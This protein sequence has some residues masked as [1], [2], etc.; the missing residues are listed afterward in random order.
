M[1]NIYAVNIDKNG[2]INKSKDIK[3]GN[4]LFPFKY[5]KKNV[6]DCL[7]GDRG[8]WCATELKDS[9]SYSK[10]A[11]CPETEKQIESSQ[12]LQ[13]KTHKSSNSS[14]KITK[15]KS[16]SISSV[17]SS[18]GD[19]ERSI[20]DYWKKHVHHE[21]FSWKQDYIYNL[22]P[23]S[24][25][26]KFDKLSKEKQL[27][28]L[29]KTAAKNSKYRPSRPP[30]P[31]NPPP[32]YQYKKHDESLSSNSILDSDSKIIIKKKKSTK[33][34][35]SIKEISL[36]EIPNSIPN[37]VWITGAPN[38]LL[39]LGKHLG[40][41]CSGYV[42]N[43]KEAREIAE[44]FNP[45]RF[46]KYHQDFRIVKF[47]DKDIELLPIERKD[48]MQKI[49]NI[50][51]VHVSQ[52]YSM[53]N[54]GD[55]TF[56][57]PFIVTSDD[58]KMSV[59]ADI[60][61]DKKDVNFKDAEI[62]ISDN[63]ISEMILPWSKLDKRDYVFLRFNDDKDKYYKFP[64]N[65]VIT[66]KDISGWCYNDYEN[67]IQIGDKIKVEKGN[68][69][70]KVGTVVALKSENCEVILDK[71][72]KDYIIS[73]ISNL[74]ISDLSII[75]KKP[76]LI[77]LNKGLII[78]PQ[79][80]M[81]TCYII[82]I[83]KNYVPEG[84]D[85]WKN[86][87]KWCL[88]NI[89]S[90]EMEN[91]WIEYDYI[92]QPQIFD[93]ENYRG[94]LPFSLLEDN[95]RI[96]IYEDNFIDKLL[97]PTKLL[98][99]EDDFLTVTFHIEK[100]MRSPS[101]YFFNLYLSQIETGT[102]EYSIKN[103]FK[104][105][106]VW[107]D[108]DVWNSFS[109]PLVDFVL[110]VGKYGYIEFLP[111][112][113]S[114]RMPSSIKE[115]NAIR[116]TLPMKYERW[117]KLFQ[118]NENKI[119]ISDVDYRSIFLRFKEK[120]KIHLKRN[121][122]E[123]NIIEK[124]IFN[125]DIKIDTAKYNNLSLD[126]FTCINNTPVLENLGYK[127]SLIRGDI[128]GVVDNS[129]DNTFMYIGQVE[130]NLINQDKYFVNINNVIDFDD[131][132]NIK[133]NSE[134]IYKLTT[135]MG[136]KIKTAHINS[137][138][139]LFDKDIII[140]NILKETR[141][142]PEWGLGIN[143][144]SEVFVGDIVYVV[145]DYQD[146]KFM[147][148]YID[149]T[150]IGVFDIKNP[151]FIYH[152]KHNQYFLQR[153]PKRFFSGNVVSTPSL[154]P[155]KSDSSSDKKYV[156]SRSSSPIYN[157]TSPTY[158]PNSPPGTPPQLPYSP[159][160][161]PES[162]PYDPNSPQYKPISPYSMKDGKTYIPISVY[163]DNNIYEGDPILI[164]WEFKSGDFY[165]VEDDR[166]ISVIRNSHNRPTETW[167]IYDNE[168]YPETK[169][170]DRPPKGWVQEDLFY[171]NG[172]PIANLTM[173][174]ELMK[175][176]VANNWEISLQNVKSNGI[177]ILP[178]PPKRP[179]TKP[180]V[181]VPSPEPYKNYYVPLEIGQLIIVDPSEYKNIPQTPPFNTTLVEYKNNPSLRPD[182]PPLSDEEQREYNKFSI[183]SQTTGIVVKDDTS[184]T[185]KVYID[186]QMVP[187]DIDI[188]KYLLYNSEFKD[189][190]LPIE[191]KFVKE[192]QEI[193]ITEYWKNKIG[194]MNNRNIK[195][196]NSENR[197]FNTIY[198]INNEFPPD[199]KIIVDKYGDAIFQ[200]DRFNPIYKAS[201]RDAF[202]EKYK[203]INGKTFWKISSESLSYGKKKIKTF[204]FA[205]SYDPSSITPP[206]RG[207]YGG[208][209]EKKGKDIIFDPENKYFDMNDFQPSSLKMMNT[210]LMPLN[211]KN[212]DTEGCRNCGEK[213]CIQDCPK[214]PGKHMG[215]CNL[216]GEFGHWRKDCPK[217][218]TK[219]T[220]KKRDSD[221]GS[222]HSRNKYTKK[223]RSFDSISSNETESSS[224][225]K[226]SSEKKIKNTK[227]NKDKKKG[228]KKIS[229]SMLSLFTKK[230]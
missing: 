113:E 5:K 138:Y 82:Q 86:S 130:N 16:S 170:P 188:E 164:G 218:L 214:P 208:K 133:G 162:P 127:L 165:N 39:Y 197:F 177:H 128:V 66:D 48:K 67:D 147:V 63:F 151:S 14:S 186:V 180:L 93:I 172:D 184:N 18:N 183:L 120:D 215:A 163:H 129:S 150:T 190:V 124:I 225:K 227:K 46:D 8:K 6:N 168:D 59:K 37:P 1:E 199:E 121:T 209:D 40:N 156:K 54:N 38:T 110:G 30:S 205:Y 108:F 109:S 56:D 106:E 4:C 95:S 102:T 92:I 65:Q 137:V 171:D 53:D 179:K 75:L 134:I 107:L 60:M 91:L 76:D 210:N 217:G 57:I 196:Q 88:V 136:K 228:T 175:N 94:T 73:D 7:T 221:S 135:Q 29:E 45:E 203:T 192:I 169:N 158:T 89:P 191:R 142:L 146:R 79:Y 62:F 132:K 84:L 202:I 49:G 139:H 143:Y 55:G 10:Y 31:D 229:A 101:N 9:G 213:H 115:I 155:E 140:Y 117:I 34:T 24:K 13:K 224:S 207:W 152:L 11:Y 154:S 193:P 81:E 131:I 33:P 118:E 220:I 19:N 119:D 189:G 114:K 69:K 230:K 99:D 198:R 32:M 50:D 144:P 167:W 104:Y 222:Q 194:I 74:N 149:E 145:D 22:L 28:F 182:T 204:Y 112:K 64:C 12:K 3:E 100:E 160:Y 126:S 58:H 226:S 61:G 27:I 17:S 105:S 157:P 173:V 51:W 176:E 181:K 211:Y 21:G 85:P 116:K 174:A 125:K 216:C 23:E 47:N 148:K 159:P 122:K 123:D 90:V 78:S 44:N 70:G 97:V 15:K 41:N 2:K 187:E 178:S 185:G 96:E 166:Y 153:D 26:K 141:I 36:T 20:K 111:L 87:K 68:N 223:I 98:K 77:P 42:V 43:I 195:I 161:A 201:D 219:K 212:N 80:Y 52:I 206:Y 35:P 71:S 83:R 72:D 25:K 200:D 103:I